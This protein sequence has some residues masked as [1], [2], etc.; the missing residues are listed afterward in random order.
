MKINIIKAVLMSFLVGAIAIPAFALAQTAPVATGQNT[1]GETVA[2]APIAVGQNTGGE[3]VATAPIAVGQNTGGETVAPATVVNPPASN[4]GGSVST[5]G[6]SSVSSSGGG[7]YIGTGSGSLP[8]LVSIGQCQYLS[9]Y[10]KI[11]DANSITDVTRLQTFL[12]NTEGLNV[13]IIGSFDQ[14]TFDAVSAFQVKYAND[15]L[16][17]WGIKSP[18]GYIYYTTQKKI[19]EIYCKTTFALTISQIAEIEA[20][21]TSIINGNSSTVTGETGINKD[22]TKTSTSTLAAGTTTDDTQ[23]AAVT[24][25]SFAQKIWNFIKRI[26]GR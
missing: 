3:T 10:L 9:T 18:T 12:K 2:T 21:R 7:N 6:G 17:P 16:L 25:T 19:N 5:G 8:L 20:Y 4:G 22:A 14:K 24:K 23:I 15:V 26:F 1:G 11:G 13:D